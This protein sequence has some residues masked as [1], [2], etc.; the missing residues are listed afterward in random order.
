MTEMG[1]ETL[2]TEGRMEAKI[3][4]MS[5]VYNWLL[6]MGFATSTIMKALQEFDIAKVN[7]YIY[8]LVMLITIAA[9][10]LKIYNKYVKKGG[11]K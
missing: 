9:G 3:C 7:Q 1:T 5:K 8:T 2:T 6:G 4:V 11:G 10:L